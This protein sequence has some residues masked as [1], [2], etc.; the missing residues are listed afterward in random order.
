[1]S[2]DYKNLY[3][4]NRP[5]TLS[6]SFYSN[7]ELYDFILPTIENPLLRG[8]I[9]LSH[10]E[11]ICERPSAV[12]E[13][14]DIILDYWK[15]PNSSPDPNPFSVSITFTAKLPFIRS[16]LKVNLNGGYIAPW[17][18]DFP[19]PYSDTSTI[20]SISGSIANAG[21]YGPVFISYIPSELKYFNGYKIESLPTGVIS[22]HVKDPL[23]IPLILRLRYIID[24]IEMYFNEKEYKYPITQW[25]GGMTNSSKS[26]VDNL[27]YGH[28]PVSINHIKELQ[29]A[30]NNIERF[31]SSR[32]GID[33][34]NVTRFKPFLY[35]TE[36]IE[37]ILYSTY[38]IESQLVIQQI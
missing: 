7:N 20:F 21:T 37:D 11:I 30:V 35:S 4:A 5:T 3:G 1:M 27:I 34:Y 22:A 28:T 17:E 33:G 13:N 31:M 23:T 8:D 29:L 38:K 24:N 12:D 25:I 15:D 10:T 14:D 16:S 26:Q 2:T 6:F 9:K 36:S 18:I 19:G 32:L